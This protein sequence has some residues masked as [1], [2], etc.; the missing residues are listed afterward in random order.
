MN[1][2]SREKSRRVCFQCRR[3]SKYSWRH[4][5]TST[6]PWSGLR[7]GQKIYETFLLHFEEE[8]FWKRGKTLLWRTI[9]HCTSTCTIHFPISLSYQSLSKTMKMVSELPG[10]GERLLRRPEY[11]PP[12]S[13]GLGR[14][15][16]LCLWSVFSP[17]FPPLWGAPYIRVPELPGSGGDLPRRQHEPPS[18]LGPKSILI[19][20][21][22]VGL[23]CA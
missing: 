5:T 19:K 15:I 7:P 20:R 23:E 14:S 2:G 10:S 17:N 22:Y 1:F 3:P 18:G 11:E 16:S 6:V 21:Y 12:I 8:R 9:I 4:P 13:S